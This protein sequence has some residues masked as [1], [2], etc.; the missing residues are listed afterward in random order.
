[1]KQV[2]KNELPEFIINDQKQKEMKTLNFKNTEEIFSDFVL[3]AEE[4]ICI[5]G[6]D[7]GEPILKPS[8][9]PVKI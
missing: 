7:A 6:G 5:K 9:P 8:V 2:K 3:T 4:M 1:M